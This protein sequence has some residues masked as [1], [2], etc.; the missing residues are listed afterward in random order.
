MIGIQPAFEGT[1]FLPEFH[2]L[3]RVDD[4]RVHFQAITDDA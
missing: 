2:D 3:L 1:K 4:C